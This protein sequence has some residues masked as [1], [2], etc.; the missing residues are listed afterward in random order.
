[1]NYSDSTKDF[2]FSIMKDRLGYLDIIIEPNK[3]GRIRLSE[4][5]VHF[6]TQ[7]CMKIIEHF[8]NEFLKEQKTDCSEV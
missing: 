8:V 6:G 7:Y 5:T 2:K 1:M 4:D 3:G